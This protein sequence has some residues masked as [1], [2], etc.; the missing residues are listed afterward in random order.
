MEMTK[1][2]L[3][4]YWKLTREIW[5][6]RQELKELKTSEAGVGVSVVLDYRKGY[7]H[8]QAV[9][10]FDKEKYNE[11]KKQLDEKERQAK[12]I[13]EWVDGIKDAETRVVFKYYYIDGM[14]W[15]QVAKKLGYSEN[16]DYPRLY[17]RDKYLEKKGI[18]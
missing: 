7:A 5:I 16:A 8:P 11:V 3:E 13:R 17:I 18:K 14:S 9:V 15:R 10:G 4:S 6:L 12:E 1:K 2:K